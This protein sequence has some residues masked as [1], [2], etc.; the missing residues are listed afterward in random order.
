MAQQAFDSIAPRS[1]PTLYRRAWFLSSTSCRSGAPVC[2]QSLWLPSSCRNWYIISCNRHVA[3]RRFHR[4]PTNPLNHS[5]LRWNSWIPVSARHPGP[6]VPLQ[7]GSQSQYQPPLYL[8]GLAL[9]CFT[10][11]LPWHLPLPLSEC[12]A[13]LGTSLHLLFQTG[14]LLFWHIEHQ[15]RQRDPWSR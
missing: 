2:T 5:D 10:C 11:T 6:A 8:G 1:N 14:C 7:N 9:I 3:Q 13:G 15:W 4:P 12:R